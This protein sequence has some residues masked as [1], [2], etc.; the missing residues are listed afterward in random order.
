MVVGEGASRMIKVLKTL[1]N[2][3]ERQGDT[4]GVKAR[5]VIKGTVR[6]SMNSLKLSGITRKNALNKDLEILESY[7]VSPAV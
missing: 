5:N 4:E 3:R 6:S 7:F 2:L 1:R